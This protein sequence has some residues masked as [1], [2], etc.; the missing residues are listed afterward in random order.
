MPEGREVTRYLVTITR[1][2]DDLFQ[3]ITATVAIPARQ[4]AIEQKP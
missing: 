2:R 1:D 4:A 3:S